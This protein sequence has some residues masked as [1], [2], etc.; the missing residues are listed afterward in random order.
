M[1]LY[2]EYSISEVAKIR[3][4]T[5]RLEV[6]ERIRTSGDTQNDLFLARRLGLYQPAFKISTHPKTPKDAKELLGEA[7]KAFADGELS[8]SRFKAVESATRT[9]I[10]IVEATELEERIT[11]LETAHESK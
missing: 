2:R 8:E 11:A 1:R 5:L 4:E 10:A 6:S 3:R 7:L 9:F